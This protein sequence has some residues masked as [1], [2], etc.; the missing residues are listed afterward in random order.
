MRRVTKSIMFFILAVMVMPALG[1]VSSGNLLDNPSAD[2]NMASWTASAN[3]AAVTQQNQ[4]GS[5]GPSIVL[6]LSDPKFFTMAA[7]AGSDANMYQVVDLSTLIGSVADFNAQCWV[8]TELDGSDANITANDYGEM[9]VDF[10]DGNDQSVGTFLSGPVGYPVLGGSEYAS[11]DISGAVPQAAVSAVYKLT[12]TLVKGSWI[13]VFYDDLSLAVGLKAEIEKSMPADGY[14]G[15][16]LT[17]T[18]DVENPYDSNVVAVDILPSDLRY[19]LD[20]LAV[21]GNTV[22]PLGISNNSVSVKVPPGDH[23]ITFDAQVVQA[24]AED[25]NVANVARVYNDGGIVIDDSET[26][27]LA[28]HPYAGLS[29]VIVDVNWA[30]ASDPCAIYVPVKTDVHWGISFLVENIAGD[31]IL[32]MQGVV[33][34]DRF[35]GDLEVDDVNSITAGT[36]CDLSKKKGNTLK[37]FLTWNIGNLADSN[38]AELVLEVSTDINPGTGHGKKSGHQEYTSPGEHCLNSGAVIKFI[39]P[40]TGYQL[41]A[42]TPELIVEAYEP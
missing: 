30:G 26:V 37:Q 17:I 42:H 12:G 32:T 8:Q 4:S 9:I 6:P 7:A 20:T 18:L 33:L 31:D 36:T 22:T 23:Q 24:P 29:K 14:L 13:N 1:A 38:S 34:E 10:R 15:D 3:V 2:S 25:M 35:G 27:L 28:L 19:I 39:D 16:H 5:N 40:G 11:F 21:D 41:S